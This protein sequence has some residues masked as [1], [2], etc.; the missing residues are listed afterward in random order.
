V[1][2]KNLYA[3]NHVD[4]QKS[5]RY[6]PKEKKSTSRSSASDTEIALT[7]AGVRTSSAKK[8]ADEGTSAVDMEAQA[9]A[10]AEDQEEAEPQLS[11]LV[12]IGLLVVVTVVRATSQRLLTP[13]NLYF[14]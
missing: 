3:D 14:S 10:D 8:P 13:L 6:A 11:L 2:H 5:V 4:V 9:K 7:A 1:S 12:T